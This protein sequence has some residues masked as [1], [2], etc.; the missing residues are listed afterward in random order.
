[1]IRA[2][3]LLAVFIGA[4]NLSACG[5]S[6]A[7][8]AGSKGAGDNPGPPAAGSGIASP[9]GAAAGGGRAADQNSLVR[10]WVPA[11]AQGAHPQP[12]YVE[13]RADGTWT[14]SD[15]CNGLRGTWSAEP[16]GQWQATVGPSTKIFC[17][18]VNV[19]Q[20]L[21]HANR[22]NLDGDLLILFDGAGQETGRFRPA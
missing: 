18:N 13:L 7:D 14:G 9:T 11:V 19:G 20:W 5:P 3:L 8:S 21:E 1:M 16:A 4:A 2:I 15:G 6:A 17:D 12:P 10:R 22:A